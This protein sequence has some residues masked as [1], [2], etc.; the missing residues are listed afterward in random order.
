[1]GRL[2]LDRERRE[3]R[4]YTNQLA[5]TATPLILVLSPFSRGE[6]KKVAFSLVRISAVTSWKG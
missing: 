3:V 1:M 6:A 2:S 5:R 4:V